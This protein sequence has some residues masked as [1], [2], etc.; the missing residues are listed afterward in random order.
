MLTSNEIEQESDPLTSVEKTV[1]SSHYSGYYN[2]SNVIT[3]NG[4]IAIAG[5]DVT[6][7]S[8]GNIDFTG[9]TGSTIDLTVD[10]QLRAFCNSNGENNLYLWFQRAQYAKYMQYAGV[11]LTVVDTDSNQ[12]LGYSSAYQ[13]EHEPYYIGGDPFLISTPEGSAVS[14]VPGRFVKASTGVYYFTSNGGSNT[15]R[16]IINGC[17]TA[18]HMKVCINTL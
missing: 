8:S 12:V 2:S 11:Y 10:F 3:A 16:L 13:F 1:T 4:R 7:D 15:W 14:E 5:T 18:R 17:P 9:A 6:T